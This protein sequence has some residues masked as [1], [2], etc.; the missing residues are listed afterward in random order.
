[1][2]FVAAIVG[3]ERTVSAVDGRPNLLGGSPTPGLRLDE[4]LATARTDGAARA[5]TRERFLRD[6]APEDA[7][8]A[9]VLIE[10][11]EQGRPVV[12]SA[13]G[14]RHHRGVL[15]G[16]GAD[17]VALRTVDGNDVLVA[18]QAVDA[19]RACGQDPVAP[20]EASTGL[21]AGMVEA[22]AVLAED[23]PRVL[24]VTLPSGEG[25]AGDLVAVGRDVLTLRLDGAARDLAYLAVASVATVTVA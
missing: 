11:A 18:H 19:V 10:L 22:L 24:V 3:G 25:L 15:R 12:V 16:V 4:W 6:T 5:R 14:G 1:M 2:A 23:R 7:T 9:G 20:G 21:G 8:F 13:G 17:F